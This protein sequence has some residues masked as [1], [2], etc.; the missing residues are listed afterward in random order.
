MA[1]VSQMFSEGPSIDRPPLFV[2]E[3]Y[4]LWKIRMKI[5]LE[6]IDMGVW[7]AIVNGP[8][9]PM[10]TINNVHVEKDF[11]LWTADENK[12]VQ[13]DARAKYIIHSALTMEEF[14]KVSTCKN[15]K[16]MWKT[17]EKAQGSIEE[18]G[19]K[20]SESNNS[21]KYINTCLMID[22][23]SQE[24]KISTSNSNIQ[25]KYDEVL[26]TFEELHK[27]AN[28]LNCLNK[29]L[30]IDYQELEKRLNQLEEENKNLDFDLENLDIIH[31]TSSC[32]CNSTLQV[33]NFDCKDRLNFKNRVE[34]LEEKSNLD[35][36]LNSQKCV[37]DEY[38][39]SFSKKQKS[40]KNIFFHPEKAFNTTFVS[41]F[42]CLK[43]GH[44]SN[45]C[46]FKNVGVPSGKY[47]WLPKNTIYVA[48][49]KEPQY[50]VG[51]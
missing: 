14:Y 2:G 35:T 51:T 50:K 24:S 18:H 25:A 4:L 29:K 41:C 13:Y 20:N 19:H 28:E 3:N 37:M 30:N 42:Y 9:I 34:F 21:S 48:N 11:N 45:S 17:L 8:F 1:N 22:V 33:K 5:F 27:E 43:N 12:K 26:D 39:Y 15:A 49:M 38:G 6:S 23:E 44:T 47:L 31:K 32:N 16:K 36:L 10:H 46:Y 40:F 7:D